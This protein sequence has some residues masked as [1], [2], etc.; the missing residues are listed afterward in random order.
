MKI[1]IDH[2]LFKR[3]LKTLYRISYLSDKV[4]EFNSFFIE[5]KKDCLVIFARNRQNEM[6]R[7]VPASS[8][9]QI[10]TPG[11][12]VVNAFVLNEI[13]Q[14]TKQ[15]IYLEALEKTVATLHTETY[16]TKINL[17]DL[18]QFWESFRFD[19]EGTQTTF[20]TLALQK[21]MS[22]VGYAV[23]TKEEGNPVFR[24]ISLRT[25]KQKLIATAT[26]GSRI[27]RAAL[28]P[29]DQELD[30]VLHPSTI[31]EA[32]R[33][34]ELEKNEEIYAT[35]GKTKALFQIGNGIKL[36]SF[37]LE[38]AKK[39]PNTEKHFANSF[40]TVVHCQKNELIDAVEK[41]GVL[42]KKEDIPSVVLRVEQG[43]FFV[44]SLD[45]VEIG[46]FEQRVSSEKTLGSDKKIVLQ[47]KF[48]LSALKT[49][50][51]QEVVISFSADDGPVLFGDQKDDNLKT[52]ILPVW[53]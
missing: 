30:L 47:T 35:F 9:L 23:S 48:V 49:F 17:S 14:R 1:K 22:R 8:E 36:S 51:S 26:D 29:L 39:F 32:V 31:S 28:F 33:V 52:L 53:V 11:K 15:T 38:E 40:E 50:P 34:S 18:D 42:F 21:L 41:A 5:A 10:L 44:S 25:Q 7:V 43:E 2:L 46:F 13:V 27:A 45:S 16:Q 3:V 19:A 12:I 20:P 4:V 24:G 37:V 6:E